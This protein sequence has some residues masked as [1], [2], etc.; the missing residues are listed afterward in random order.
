MESLASSRYSP[1]NRISLPFSKTFRK[2]TIQDH[3]YIAKLYE[4]YETSTDFY[5]VFEFCSGGELFSRIIA[6]GYFTEQHA[7]FVMRDLMCGLQYCHSLGIVHRDVKPENCLFANSHMNSSL[8]LIDFG[9]SN[10]FENPSIFSIT[11]ILQK[12]RKLQ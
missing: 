1:R 8:K 3:P 4:Y 9:L 2:S 11:E 6:N 7:A 10:I 12:M 5:L